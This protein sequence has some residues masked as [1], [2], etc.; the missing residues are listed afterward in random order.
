M[1]ELPE[2]ID[3]EAFQGFVDMR[4][5]KGK[6]APFTERAKTLVLNKL[7]EFHKQGLDVNACLDQATEAGWSS[8]YPIKTSVQSVSAVGVPA[9]VKNAALAAHAKRDAELSNPDVR[10][11]AD[12][13]RRRA[14]EQAKA[15]IRRVA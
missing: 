2:Y 13:A 10:A 9:P 6:R 1:A 8:V 15:S 12:E 14:I 5:A 11:A 3:P 7:A 4:R